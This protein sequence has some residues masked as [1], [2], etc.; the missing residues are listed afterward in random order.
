MGITTVRRWLAGPAA[1]LMLSILA[2]CGDE[3]TI[4]SGAPDSATTTA[5]ET[6]TISSD[7]AE[8]TPTMNGDDSL[9][10]GSDADYDPALQ[11]LVDQAKDD[12]AVRLGVAPEAITVV[13][14][15]MVQWPDA[16]NG[17]PQ[18]GM[19]YAQVVSDG[20]EI[21]LATGGAQYRYTTGGTSYT[22]VFCP[23]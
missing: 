11:P 20:S 5:D 9:P 12:L 2:A 3:G 1:V 16:A 7:S 23:S 21:V 15:E 17:C 6:T 22:P 19:S 4:D 18:P 14:A 8:E 10:G 13:S